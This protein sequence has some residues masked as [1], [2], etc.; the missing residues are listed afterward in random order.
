MRILP[1]K[2][3][4]VALALFAMTPLS[5]KA[6][7]STVTG[8]SSLEV[9]SNGKIKK[10]AKKTHRY[11]KKFMKAKGV[12]GRTERAAHNISVLA[13]KAYKGKVSAELGR[14]LTMAKMSFKIAAQKDNKRNKY[15]SK[16][17]KL[18]KRTH[19]AV[20]TLID[21]VEKKTDDSDDKDDVDDMDDLDDSD[22]DIDDLDDDS[23]DL[24]DDSDD[25]DDKDDH[26]DHD[27]H[28]DSDDS[29][30]KDDHDDFN[31]DNEMD[32][33]SSSDEDDV[34]IIDGK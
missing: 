27:D 31:D 24:D 13:K 28:D 30:D 7:S 12:D 29:D 4:M 11:A 6:T 26:D 8:S 9:A 10:Q 19:K 21:L 32:D 20:V 15:P 23:D 33:D 1:V 16:T 5:A 25:H 17:K 2:I 3:L 18:Y 34:I 22:D 14:R